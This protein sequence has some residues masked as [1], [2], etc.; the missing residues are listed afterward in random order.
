MFARQECE[1]EGCPDIPQTEVANANDALAL[2]TIGDLALDLVPV[3][4]ANLGRP[5]LYGGVCPSV[6]HRLPP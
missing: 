6:G 1:Q 5:V 4:G 2:D 3:P